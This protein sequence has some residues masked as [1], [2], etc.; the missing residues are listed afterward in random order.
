[1]AY[2]HK[3]APNWTAEEIAKLWALRAEGRTRKEIAAILGR[4]FCAVQHRIHLC[5]IAESRAQRTTTTT[6]ERN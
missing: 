4:S 2:R 1:M 5:L 3:Q 6:N